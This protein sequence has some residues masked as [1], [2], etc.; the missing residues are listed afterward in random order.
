MILRVFA[1]KNWL[2]LQILKELV[3]IETVVLRRSVSEA[4]PFD[5]NCVDTL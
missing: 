2:L 1:L 5:T 3:S 4:L